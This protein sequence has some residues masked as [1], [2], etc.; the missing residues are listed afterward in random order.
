MYVLACVNLGPSPKGTVPPVRKL[1]PK[2]IRRSIQQAHN[3]CYN[4]EDTPACRVMWDRVDELSHALARQ[5][6]RKEPDLW[7][8]LE[9]R[10]YDV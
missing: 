10:E 7:D 5:E 8:E 4:S 6:E 1:T 9:T 2:D 3:V